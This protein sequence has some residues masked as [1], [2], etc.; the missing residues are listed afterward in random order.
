MTNLKKI[1]LT[2]LAGT[3]AATTFAQAGELT[4]GGTARMEYQSTTTE[5][6]A[7]G[8]SS[9]DTFAQ[10]GTVVFSGTG[11]MDNGHT[12]SYMQA[13][14][15]GSLTSQSVAVDM[16]DM[17]TVSMASLNMAGIGTI[18]DMVPNGGEQPWDDLELTKDTHGIPQVGLASPHAGNRLGYKVEAGGAIISAAANYQFAAATTSVAVQMPNLVE[19]FNIGAGMA[20]DQESETVENDIETVF[21]TY[22]MGAVSVGVQSTSI[23]HQTASS[24]IQRDSYGISFAVNDNFSIGYGASDVEF[25]ALTKDEE[26]RGIGAT[27]T[28]GG[29]KIGFINNQKDNVAGGTSNMEMNE[30]QLT[31]AF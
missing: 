18:Q 13:L 11:E 22:T 9:A 25:D 23:D 24:D 10:N 5:T 12:V 30:L 31:F 3:L 20:T 1:G 17:G 6:A 8:N 7:L 26:S 21:L 28:M 2:A 14:A 27:Y 4:V 15:G 19:G 29:M 16:G